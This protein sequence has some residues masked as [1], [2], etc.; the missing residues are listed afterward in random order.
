MANL[1]VSLGIAFFLCWGAARPE[2][3]TDFSAIAICLILIRIAIIIQLCFHKL[4][5]II[6]ILV[7][8]EE[9]EGYYH[10]PYEIETEL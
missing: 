6:D 4:D 8:E 3:G 5:E 2:S 10:E 7:E 1:I 9:E